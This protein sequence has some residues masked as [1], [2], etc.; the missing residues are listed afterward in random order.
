MDSVRTGPSFL[1]SFLSAPTVHTSPLFPIPP[2]SKVKI[3]ITPE[4]YHETTANTASVT[5]THHVRQK[6]TTT[7]TKHTTAAAKIH[8]LHTAISFSNFSS[9]TLQPNTCHSRHLETPKIT[10]LID[11]PTPKPSPHRTRHSPHGPLGYVN[12]VPSHRAQNWSY[13]TTCS[14]PHRT[15]TE[16]CVRCRRGRCLRVGERAIQT[17]TGAVRTGLNQSPSICLPCLASAART[18]EWR[19]HSTD[20]HWQSAGAGQRPRIREQKNSKFS[21]G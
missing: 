3:P 11:T 8:H 9:T 17:L 14:G 21:N 1:I 12:R 5:K 19:P 2:R 10:L 20:H 7:G 16:Y 4:I 6:H 15:R 18:I 13:D